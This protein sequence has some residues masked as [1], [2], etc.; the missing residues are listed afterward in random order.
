MFS[1]VM[2]AA[3]TLLISQSLKEFL[4]IDDKSALAMDSLEAASIMI[5]DGGAKCV[6][7]TVAAASSS[8]AAG[9]S[10]VSPSIS[11]QEAEAAG[12]A[13]MQRS[14]IDG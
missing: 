3:Q 2:I 5:I 6:R 10:S 1:A 14:A 11:S 8:K 13:V 4:G 9:K 7:N 12:A